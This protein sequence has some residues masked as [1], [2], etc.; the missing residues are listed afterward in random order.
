M[1][2]PS[3]ALMLNL[4]AGRARKSHESELSLVAYAK[5]RQCLGN[6]RTTT[7]VLK[8]GKECSW[9][10][11]RL[12]RSRGPSEHAQPHLCS[13]RLRLLLQFPP[14][15]IAACVS[16]LPHRSQSQNGQNP[17]AAVLRPRQTA[18]S[19]RWNVKLP[20]RQSVSVRH[21]STATHP[22]RPPRLPFTRYPS[23]KPKPRPA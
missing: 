18:S 6:R 23:R 13:R 20:S 12:S 17:G 3:R 7:R 8:Q 19:P 22:N 21:R 16:S 10:V 4:S 15:A 1:F 14:C 9:Q 2:F 11:H 5:I